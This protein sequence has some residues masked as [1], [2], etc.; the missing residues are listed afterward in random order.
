MKMTF[1]LVMLILGPIIFIAL[2]FAGT[3]RLLKVSTFAFV[4]TFGMN[5]KVLAVCAAVVVYWVVRG[6]DV[7]GVSGTLLTLATIPCACLLWWFGLTWL[8]DNSGRV[9]NFID[10][11]N[12]VYKEEERKDKQR[13]HEQSRKACEAFDKGYNDIVNNK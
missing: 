7:P 10:K 5:K 12:R 11:W 2:G 6:Y 13:Q 1:G 3:L 9:S 8:K 4:R